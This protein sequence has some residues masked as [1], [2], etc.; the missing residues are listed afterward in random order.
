[1][2]KPKR[3]TVDNYQQFKP[4][5]FVASFLSDLE[6]VEK[7]KKPMNMSRWNKNN[8]WERLQLV[9]CLPCLGGMACMNLGAKDKQLP[10]IVA[11]EG[12][13]VFTK[14]KK[15]YANVALLGDCIRMGEKSGIKIYLQ[16]LYPATYYSQ[17]FERIHFYGL[18]G[19]A[20]LVYPKS[21]DM[22]HLK[23]NIN[24][25]VNALEKAG[26]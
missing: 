1:M 25:I 17:S 24:I 15:L 18:M 21:K 8:T 23:D 11:Y 9:E 14:R 26:M 3:I 22:K 5:E 13:N 16:K 4:S 6:V 2:R 20:G 10:E 7:Q 19:L 12:L